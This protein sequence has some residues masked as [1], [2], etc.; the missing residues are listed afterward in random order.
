[1]KK[2]KVF[3]C[4]AGIGTQRMALRNLGINFQSVGI[5]EIDIPAILSYASIHDNL[6]SVEI[7][8]P[9]KEEMIYFLTNKNIGL[10]FKTKKISLPKQEDKLKLL[11]KATILSNCFGDVSLLNVK[12]LPDFDLFTYS[13]PCQSISIAGKREGIKK[14]ETK[15]GLL[16]ECE[17]VIKEKKPK[18]LLLEN[19]KPLVGK[20]RPQFE[21]WLKF[22]NSLGYTNYW[23]VLN[24]IDYGVAQNRERVFVVSILNDVQGF[25]FDDKIPLTKTLKDYVDEVVDEKYIIA[26]QNMKN[27]CCNNEIWKERVKIK[28]LEE[29]ANCLVAKSGKACRTN[30]YILNNLKDYQNLSFKSN[31]IMKIMENGYK[32]RALTPL[33]YWRLMGCS[34]EDFYK[35]EKYNSDAQLYK[36]AGN[37]IVVNILE[38]IFK[39]LFKEE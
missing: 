21:E 9:S 8:Y 34:D 29:Y 2:I 23:K 10:N 12:E 30:N 17:R 38:M 18:Y 16:Y 32:I 26:Y 35:A 37:A 7:N 1:M 13:F 39:N 4:F 11:Y 19:V 31:E 24:A 27:F 36:Q 15:S 22:L 33:E 5:S 25:E 20:F 28:T 14:N 3:E 6:D